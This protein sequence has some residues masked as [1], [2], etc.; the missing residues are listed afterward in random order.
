MVI[1]GIL[2]CLPTQEQPK[3]H[4]PPMESLSSENLMVYQPIL[5]KSILPFCTNKSLHQTPLRV[6]HVVCLGIWCIWASTNFLVTPLGMKSKD[7][8]DSMNRKYLNHVRTSSTTSWCLILR[9][10]EPMNR[11]RMS[12]TCRIFMKMRTSMQNSKAGGKT[13][14]PIALLNGLASNVQRSRMWPWFWVL[15]GSAPRDPLSLSYTVL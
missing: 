2:D 7:K 12:S 9:M 4:L 13:T 14:I 1:E 15:L 10:Y 6:L 11:K 8:S 5:P 3:V